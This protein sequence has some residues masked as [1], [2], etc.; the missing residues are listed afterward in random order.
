MRITP[1]FLLGM[2]CC[3]TVA[4]GASADETIASACS[5]TTYPATVV[6]PH[7][8]P[9]IVIQGRWMD[10][11]FKQV[12]RENF[13]PNRVDFA[14]HYQF[15]S[16]G[17]GTQCSEIAMVDILSGKTYPMPFSFTGYVHYS[18]NSYMII[19]YAP[20]SNDVDVYSKQWEGYYVLQEEKHSFKH[21]TQCED[22]L[23]Q[24]R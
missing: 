15:I 19:E 11:H 8:V 23:K 2:I 7:Q 5:L 1:Y 9:S 21:L 14:G 22:P 4:M 17:C 16:R 24:K 6:I 20:D 10:D 18:D 12:V 13:Q 3:S